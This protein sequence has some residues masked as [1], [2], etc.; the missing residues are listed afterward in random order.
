MGLKIGPI[1]ITSNYTLKGLTFRNTWA[2]QFVHRT[3]GVE[4]IIVD[5]F[6]LIA[7]DLFEFGCPWLLVVPIHCPKLTAVRLP[8][9]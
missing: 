1:L 9:Y 8:S 4:S 6:L 7:E 5:R 2:K 3:R